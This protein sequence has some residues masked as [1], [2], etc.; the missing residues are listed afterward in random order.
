VDNAFG[1]REEVC[2][3]LLYLHEVLCFVM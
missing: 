1:V 2:F 3:V